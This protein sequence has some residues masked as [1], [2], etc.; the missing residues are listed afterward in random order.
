VVYTYPRRTLWGSLVAQDVLLALVFV[1]LVVLDPGGALVRALAL[2]IPV[3]LVWGVVTLHH[4]IVVVVDELG[5]AFSRYGIVHRF[6]WAQLEA[7]RVRR[8]LVRDRVLV[9]L[10]PSPPWRGRYWIL[11]GIEGFDDL[12]RALEARLP[13]ERQ[14]QPDGARP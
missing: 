1:G 11:D 13:R 5:I 12:V 8:F 10:T 7:V 14:P 4:P 6:E 2:A 3:V 9:R